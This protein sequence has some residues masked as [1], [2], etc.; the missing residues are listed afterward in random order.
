[1]SEAKEV[2][3]AMIDH[4][5]DIIAAGKGKIKIRVAMRLVG[6][7]DEQVKNMTLYQKV[8]RKAERMTVV[9]FDNQLERI[10]N[11]DETDGLLD[12]SH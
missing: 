6:F 3:E 11:L 2:E 8:R 4:A 5:S 10:V 9:V 12:E 7:S 1:M